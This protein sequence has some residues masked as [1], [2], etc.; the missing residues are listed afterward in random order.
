M[1]DDTHLT[2]RAAA[3]SQAPVALLVCSPRALQEDGAHEEKNEA[4]ERT[5]YA[6][7]GVA[8]E[9]KVGDAGANFLIYSATASILTRRSARHHFVPTDI[10]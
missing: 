3:R 2:V 1:L 6:C 5:S 9:E 7:S 10:N 8:S 4:L